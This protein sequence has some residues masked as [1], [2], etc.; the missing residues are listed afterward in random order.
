MQLLEAAGAGNGR[1]R[2]WR[3]GRPVSGHLVGNPLVLPDPADALVGIHRRLVLHHPSAVQWLHQ[4][5]G[6]GR[7]SATENHP[8][9]QDLRR[10]H[11]R[12]EANMWRLTQH[13]P[14]SISLPV[15]HERQ[16]DCAL[17]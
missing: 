12:N 2:R 4:S 11:D 9:A 16:Y 13:P 6:P 3:L 10:E 7:R 15:G 8:T 14:S 5:T 17:G 1:G